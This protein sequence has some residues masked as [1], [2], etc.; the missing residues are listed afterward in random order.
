MI[1]YFFLTSCANAHKAL[2]LSLEN[3]LMFMP[4]CVHCLFSVTVEAAE[5]IRKCNVGIKC[6][7]ITPDEKRVTGNIAGNFQALSFL[8]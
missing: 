2:P 3:D 1:N 8:G 4:L 7:T 5:A 6:A